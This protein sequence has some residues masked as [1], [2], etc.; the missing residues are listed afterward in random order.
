MSLKQASVYSGYGQKALIK[1]AKEGKIKGRQRTDIDR[2]DW[3]FD[4]ESIDAYWHEP[5][6]RRTAIAKSIIDLKRRKA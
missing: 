2:G 5:F 6:N 3:S 4:K 1:L